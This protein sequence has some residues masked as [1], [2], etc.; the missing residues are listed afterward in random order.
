MIHGIH[1]NTYPVKDQLKAMGCRWSKISECWV[2][3][4]EAV[5]AKAQALVD[6]QPAKQGAKGGPR[7]FT[8]AEFFGGRRNIEY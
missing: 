6:A 7:N 2:T 3:E 4:D 8:A 5:R 1:G